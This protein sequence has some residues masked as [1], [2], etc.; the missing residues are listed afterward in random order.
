[1]K[2][3]VSTALIVGL[4]GLVGCDSKAQLA[5][6]KSEQAW[7]LRQEQ[8]Q[9]QIIENQRTAMR[10]TREIENRKNAA[11]LKENKEHILKQLREE[12]SRIFGN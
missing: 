5:R 2:Y 9:L 6:E 12:N 10:R 1:M 7:R 11:M 3:L 8:L 4:V